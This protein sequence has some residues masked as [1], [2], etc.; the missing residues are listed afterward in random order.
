M[1][2]KYGRFSPIPKKS[3]IMAN[4]EATLSGNSRAM[5]E[6][7]PEVNREIK[8]VKFKERGKC[9]TCKKHGIPTSFKDTHDKSQAEKNLSILEQ[10][11]ASISNQN[12]SHS[13][14]PNVQSPLKSFK[15]CK[16]VGISFQF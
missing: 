12:Q 2:G 6:K 15:I 4:I 16:V 11:E 10:T 8:T 5:A 14:D 7:L 1:L 3:S 13:S 9:C